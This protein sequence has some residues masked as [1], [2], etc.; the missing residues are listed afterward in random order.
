MLRFLPFVCVLAFAQDP[1]L[2]VGGD[3]AHPL[4]LSRSDLA[5]MPRSSATAGERQKV[6]YDGV[7]LYEI[8]KRAGAPLDKELTGKALSTYILA[9]ASDGYQAL[10][11][12]AEVDPAFSDANILIADTADGKPLDAY[13]VVVPSDK[14][15]ARS[16]RMLERITVVRLKK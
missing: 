2:M 1:K 13:R 7:L 14:K 12:I 6:K 8:L 11:A 9:D 15:G 4:T 3:V 10:F 16:V 5:S